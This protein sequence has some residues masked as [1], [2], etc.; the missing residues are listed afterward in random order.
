MLPVHISVLVGEKC[1]WNSF[2]EDCDFS[3]VAKGVKEAL[4]IMI[5]CVSIIV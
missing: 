1:T 4:K 5:Q 3:M 2:F